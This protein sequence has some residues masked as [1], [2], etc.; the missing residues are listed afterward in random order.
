MITSLCYIIT[1]GHDLKYYISLLPDTAYNH[2]NEELDYN[3]KGVDVDLN[4]IA[5]DMTEWEER[6][7][8]YLGLTRTNIHDIKKEIDILS[9]QRC[10]ACYSY[11][12]LT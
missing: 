5:E 1:I 2:L 3:N 4:E 8:S 6:L 9:L 11:C 12:V 10:V 7:T